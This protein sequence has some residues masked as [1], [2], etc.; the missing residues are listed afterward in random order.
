MANSL[1]S[2]KNRRFRISTQLYSGIG[3]AVAL[4]VAASLVGWF[5]FNQVGEAQSDV[6]E[7]AI[8]EMAAAFEIAQYSGT[9]VVAAPRLTAAETPEIFE[10]IYVSIIEARESF[11]Q[12]LAVLESSEGTDERSQRI[13]AHS[14]TLTA[15]IEAIK[16]QGE[17]MFE[18]AVARENLREQIIDLRNHLER[19][20]VSAIDDQYFYTATGYRDL[21]TPPAERSE[22]LSEEELERY[23][24]LSELQADANIATE[25]LVNAFT[26]SSAATIEPL[27]ERFEAAASR[28]ERNMAVLQDSPFHAELIPAFDELYTLGTG[29][30]S[31]FVLL[32]EELRLAENQ[33][34]LLAYNSNEA[35][36]LIAEVDSLV[37]AASNSAQ[38]ATDASANA[39]FTGRTLLLSISIVSIVGAILIAWL[40]VGRILLSRIQRLSDWMHRMAEGELELEVEIGGNDEVTDM[41]GAL[42]VFRRHALEVQRLNL[43]EK[44]AEDLKTKNDELESVLDK[45]RKAQDQIVMQEKLAALGELTAGVAH[46]IRNPLN[47]VKNFSEASEELLE[48]LH[49]V[50]NENDEQLSEDQQ[51][52][53]QEIT[54]DLNSNFERIK[55]HGER[56]DRIVH[57]MLMLGRGE[58]KHQDTDINNLLDEH[59]RLAYHSVRASDSDFQLDIKE[60][61]DPDAGVLKVISQDLGR[62]FLNMVN[63]SCYAIDEKRREKAAAGVGIKDYMPTLWLTTRRKEDSVEI[64]IKDNG[65]GIPPDVMKKI[66]DPFFTTKPTDKGTGLGLAMSSDIIREHGGAIRVDTEVGEFTEMIIEL[67]LTPAEETAE[68]AG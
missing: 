23:R 49:E 53:I 36:S 14:D 62:V 66:F 21:G 27:R 68:A 54:D 10:E 12:Q 61:F 8:P 16:D 47:F 2:L 67:P 31:G 25:L 33:R 44:L 37:I 52:L 43:V 38:E 56:A 32:Q 45:L 29:E 60:D 22:H 18:L 48:E 35:A 17:R 24:H 7:G 40:F 11:D 5:S 59:A 64:R 46:E 41:A 57:D 65:P 30:E 28:I 15:N 58:A 42:E 63:N 50:L 39:I 19:L 51:D 6:N 34:D 4:T 55:H 13:R 3:G 20:V 1:Q 9:L 26:H